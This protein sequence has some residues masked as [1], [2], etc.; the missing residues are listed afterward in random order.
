MF[1]LK[2]LK[3][4]DPRDL[5]ELDRDDLLGYLGLQT[6]RSSGDWVAPTLAAFGAGVLV[7][8]GVG[9]LMAPKPGNELRNDLRSKLQQ[10]TGTLGNLTGANT[11]VEQRP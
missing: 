10:G 1:N 3:N 11:G 7:G 5:R 6:R 4:F 2:T 9:L 8:V